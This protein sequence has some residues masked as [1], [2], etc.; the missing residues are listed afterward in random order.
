L[1][2]HGR[3]GRSEVQALRKGVTH[4]SGPLVSVA[5]LADGWLRQR[6]AA[7]QKLQF[8]QEH[9]SIKSEGIAGIP[10]PA[11]TGWRKPPLLAT[12]VWRSPGAACFA[13]RYI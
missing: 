11:E 3:G 9:A 10:V 4:P 5:V 6:R 13:K 7:K 12:A 1:L 2:P 8:W